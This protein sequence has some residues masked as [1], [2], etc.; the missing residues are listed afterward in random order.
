MAQVYHAPSVTHHQFRAALAV[1][2]RRLPVAVLQS[3]FFA[4]FFFASPFFA[5]PFFAS[6]FFASPFFA[7]LFQSPLTSPRPGA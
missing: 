5:S 7:S 1:P 4:P 6:P 3:P 2:M